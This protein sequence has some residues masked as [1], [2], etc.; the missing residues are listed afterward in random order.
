MTLAKLFTGSNTT[1]ASIIW[2]LILGAFVAIVVSIINKRNVRKLVKKLLEADASTPESAISL[3]EAGLQRNG[4]LRY[5]TRPTSTLTSIISV[6]DDKKLYISDEKSFRAETTYI[7]DRASTITIIVAAV[8]L[9]AAGVLMN[10][11]VPKLIGLA[12][13]LF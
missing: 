12:E 4:Y 1:L 6:T 8:L 3:E 10:N 2:P 13:K 9:I 11:M 5:A 7:S